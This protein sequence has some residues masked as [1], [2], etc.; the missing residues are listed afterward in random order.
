MHAVTTHPFTKITLT[1][2]I[3]VKEDIDYVILVVLHKLVEK[4]APH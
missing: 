2:K 4:L 1:T 3:I